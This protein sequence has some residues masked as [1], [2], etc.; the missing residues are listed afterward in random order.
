MTNDTALV[1]VMKALIDQKNEADELRELGKRIL[2]DFRNYSISENDQKTVLEWFRNRMKHLV[3]MDL[4][5]LRGD[6]TGLQEYAKTLG[7]EKV[8]Y[9]LLEHQWQD[10]RQEYA[11]RA[12]EAR[13]ARTP[14]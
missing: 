2:N 5:D 9:Q 10:I 13:N 6:L 1:H 4:K 3:M 12:Q 8:H 14:L 7:T 11:R